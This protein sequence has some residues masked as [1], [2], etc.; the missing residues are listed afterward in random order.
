MVGVAWGHLM[1]HN[2]AR[3][4]EEGEVMLAEGVTTGGTTPRPKPVLL[5]FAYRNHPQA[6]MKGIILKA[7]LSHKIL[8]A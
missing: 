2:L 1:S 4:A 6:G 8:G 7:V 3:S 5:S